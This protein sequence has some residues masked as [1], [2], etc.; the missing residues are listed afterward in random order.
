M[1]IGYQYAIYSP[2][3]VYIL[4]NNANIF[5]ILNIYIRYISTVDWTQNYKQY[6][7]QHILHNVNIIYWLISQETKPITQRIKLKY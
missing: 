4:R 5:K 2:H 7:S 1:R 3:F 6:E